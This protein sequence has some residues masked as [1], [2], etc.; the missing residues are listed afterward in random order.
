MV[1][2]PR[3]VLVS[4]YHVLQVKVVENAMTVLTLIKQEFIIFC[5]YYLF[6]L[7]SLS[8]GFLVLISFNFTRI[9]PR[10]LIN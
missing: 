5:F 1:L 4:V 3:V 7:Y 2:L 6:H 9:E 10:L 8:V